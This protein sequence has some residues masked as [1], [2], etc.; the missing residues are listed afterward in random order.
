MQQ[1]SMERALAAY[2][3]RCAALLRENILLEARVAELEEQAG[4]SSY[5]PA[6]ALP[7]QA[8]ASDAP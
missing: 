7:Q 3:R 5:G 8:P 1:V 2:E 6:A 4:A